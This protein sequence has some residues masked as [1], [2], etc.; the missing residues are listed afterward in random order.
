MSEQQAQQRSLAIVPNQ[1]V[2][3]GFSPKEVIAQVQA[4]Q[5]VMASVMQPEVHYGVIP[6]TGGKPSLYK[7]GAEALLSAFKIAVRPVIAESRSDDGHITYDVRC[8]G[9]HMGTGY[10]IGEGV[11]SASTAEEKYAWRGAVC[12]EEFNATPEDRKRVKW[13]KGYFDKERREQ[14][15]PY[16][17]N[18]VRTNARDQ[19]NTVLKMAKKRA[20]IDLCLTALAASDIFTQD[21]EDQDADPDAPPRQATKPKYEAKPRGNGQTGTPA[22]SSS[23]AASGSQIGLIRNRL[24]QTPEKTEAGLCEHFKLEKL[25]DLK[26]G[27]VNGVLDWIAAK[28]A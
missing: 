27:A 5:Q 15:P 14:V 18:Q 3:T 22:A 24:K 17:I 28:A 13:F 16:S 21:L 8:I 20:M 1:S 4:I 7:P 2:M 6:G 12:E 11:G 10:V 26:K 9:E 25:E 23:D 19:T